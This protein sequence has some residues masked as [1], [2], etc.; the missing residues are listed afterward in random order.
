MFERFS[1]RSR[2]VVVLAKEEASTLGHDYIG[3]EHLLLGLV[4]GESGVAAAILGAA[5]VTLEAAR[6]LVIEMVGT[7]PG[8]IPPS[9]H[10]PFTPRAKRILELSL[11]EAL[12]LKQ[13]YI[14]SEHL[15]LGLIGEEDGAGAQ[16][17]AR[18]AG[19]LPALREQVL[20]AAT[21]E[22]PE[23]VTAEEAEMWALQAARPA[24]RTVVRSRPVLGEFSGLLRSIDRRLA[25][26]EHHLGLPAEESAAPGAPG[27]P[28]AAAE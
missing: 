16:A 2:R 19:P 26:I 8:D 15:L 3:S 13:N 12:Q 6:T 25:A 7:G 22:R 10:I 11:R 4:H 20:K 9:G 24:P 23:P 14:R 28:P 18:L 1:N 17:L 5:G 21:D 27:E